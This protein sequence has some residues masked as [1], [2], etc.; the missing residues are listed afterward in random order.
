MMERSAKILIVG[1]GG[2]TE[3]SLRDYLVKSGYTN[4]FS[5]SAIGL[6]PVIQP[7]VYAFFQ[8]ERPEYVFLSSTKSGGIEANIQSAGEFLYHNLESQNN[9]IYAAH[10]FGVKKL[11][12]IAASCIYPKGCPQPMKPEYLLT[13]SF[14]PTSEAYSIAKLAGVKLC[15]TFRKQYGFKAI[16][17][18]PATLYGPGMD[19]NSKTA[20]VLGALLVKY[21][22]AVEEG[23]NTV[24]VW[25][26]GEP[27]REFLYSEDFAEGCVFL[28]DRYEGEEIIHLGA[29]EDISIK[30]LAQQIALATGFKGKTVFNTQKPDGAYQKLLDSSVLHKMGWKPK[31]SLKEGIERTKNMTTGRVK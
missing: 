14:E 26:S 21:S 28:M 29:G 11:L 24:E 1:G 10:H 13:G 30:E 17:V 27:R 25:G 15:Q 5:T 12:Y 19:M 9:V 23:Q 20:H 6:N 3:A 31:V 22:E 7:S 18:V 2:I 8:K 16:A 4:V